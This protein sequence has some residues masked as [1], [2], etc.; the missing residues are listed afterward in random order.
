MID[1]FY[2]FRY[3]T[4]TYERIELDDLDIDGDKK[5]RAEFYQATHA[6]PLRKLFKRL[7]I[8]PG[9]VLVDLGCGKGK[10]LCRN[11]IDTSEDFTEILETEIWGHEFVVYVNS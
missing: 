2:D 6:L 7:Q 3:G 1:F 5:S 9:R 10:V 8:P 11:V 4:D